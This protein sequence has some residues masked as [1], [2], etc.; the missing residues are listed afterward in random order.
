MSHKLNPEIRE[1][2]QRGFET[3]E[4]SFDLKVYKTGVLVQKHICSLTFK[5][6]DINRQPFEKTF[7][8]I[9]L[10]TSEYEVGNTY[11]VCFTI[12]HPVSR[13]KWNLISISTII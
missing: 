3:I 13:K 7:N 9:I 11:K 2:F 6:Y 1:F 12:E 5:F 10:N 4:K 8:G